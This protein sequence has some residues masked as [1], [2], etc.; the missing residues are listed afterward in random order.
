M[1]YMQNLTLEGCFHIYVLKGKF[2]SSHLSFWSSLSPVLLSPT[3]SH[4]SNCCMCSRLPLRL[5]PVINN[6]VPNSPS[7]L[8]RRHLPPPQRGQGRLRCPPGDHA[9]RICTYLSSAVHSQN[10]FFFFLNKSCSSH[11]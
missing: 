11:I 1:M 3:L 9:A 5:F 7:C 10:S 4:S 8:P 6:P 2:L